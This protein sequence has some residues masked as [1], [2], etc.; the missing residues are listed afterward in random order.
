MTWFDTLAQS[1]RGTDFRPPAMGGRE[2]RGQRGPRIR[3]ERVEEFP[4]LL[5]PATLYI[6]G[7]EPHIVGGRAAVPVRLRRR[8]RTES[9]GA[10]QP[11]LER[12]AASQRLRHPHAVRLAHERLS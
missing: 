1:V 3:Y 7:E 5:N 12:P 11:L 10:G 8:D 6:A 4:D 9:A 2:G